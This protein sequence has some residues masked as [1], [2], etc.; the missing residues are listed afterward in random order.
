MVQRIC[1]N[2]R[3]LNISTASI[4]RECGFRLIDTPEP[5]EPLSPSVALMGSWLETPLDWVGVF[6][7]GG[8]GLGRFCRGAANWNRFIVDMIAIAVLNGLLGLLTVIIALSDKSSLGLRITDIHLRLGITGDAERL[9]GGVGVGLGLAF[10]DVLYVGLVYAFT[11]LFDGKGDLSDH[12]HLFFS[13]TIGRN[14][15]A[16]LILALGIVDIRLFIG[17]AL[18]SIAY[19]YYLYIRVVQKVH[20]LPWPLAIL[21]IVVAPVVMNV[22]LNFI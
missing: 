7:S 8:L 16:P 21:P 13:A 12:L 11:L 5:L 20:Q 10:L 3:Q 15:L 2:C 19:S 22:F 1:P 6:F 17:I 9:I 14:L 18:F 4:C